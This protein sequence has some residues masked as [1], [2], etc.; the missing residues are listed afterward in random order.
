MRARILNLLETLYSNFWF[1]P[2]LMMLAAGGLFYGTTEL[3]RRLSDE[4]VEQLGWAYA[5][6][7]EGARAVLS[8]IA[9]SMITVAGVVFS[10]TIVALQLASS[11]YGSRLV[12]QFMRDKGNQIV[13]GAFVSTFLYCVLVLRTVR[14]QDEEPFVPHISV[15]VGVLL[16]IVSLVVLIYFIHHVARSIQ[17]SAII[18]SLARELNEVLDRIVPAGRDREPPDEAEPSPTGV[19]LRSERE[20]YVQILD[21]PALCRIASEADLRIAV[22]CRPGDFIFPSS[23]LARVDPPE[24]LNRELEQRIG[25]AFV[26]G[27][28]R[29]KTQDLRFTIIQ[30][31]DIAVRA[32]SP[33]VN[34]PVT[35]ITCIDCLG[36][37]L[38][39]I[40]DRP[41]PPSRFFDAEG[42]LRVVVQTETFSS[43]LATAFDPIREY[44]RGAILVSARLLETLAAIG[45]CARPDGNRAEVRAQ[46]LKI[47][48]A[49]RGR[50]PADEMPKLEQLF[51]R[52]VACTTAG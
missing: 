41:R 24:R 16:S 43:I 22:C 44:S 27:S 30:L 26:L 51:S 31:V 12:Q 17:V 2:L 8:A 32:L 42:K 14:G 3:D 45:D 13:L 5:G 9:G 6:G 52:V 49:S 4:V 35:A 1:A 33:G 38:C 47:L 36:V 34:D 10:I 50:V 20:G 46:A 37:S 23:A 28:E 40:A 19:L 48:T 11:Q 18:N 21:V 15:A 39:R 29:T 25:A 7:A